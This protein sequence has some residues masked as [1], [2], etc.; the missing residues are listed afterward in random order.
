MKMTRTPYLFAFAVTAAV[1]LTACGKKEEAA[2]RRPRSIE[3]AADSSS[4]EG[5]FG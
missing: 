4:D 1:A 5:S 3:Y 2:A